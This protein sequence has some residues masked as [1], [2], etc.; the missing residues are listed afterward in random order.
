MQV[1]SR[2]GDGMGGLVC[3]VHISRVRSQADRT[4]SK[5][6]VTERRQSQNQKHT[7]IKE[8]AY[9]LKQ[10]VLKMRGSLTPPPLDALKLPPVTTY[11]STWIWFSDENTHPPC[12]YQ[13]PTRFMI[14]RLSIETEPIS[15]PSYSSPMFPMFPGFHDKLWP[16]G[17]WQR[18]T[19]NI[20]KFPRR[21]GA[22]NSFPVLVHWLCTGLNGK[23]NADATFLSH[24]SQENSETQNHTGPPG[25]SLGILNRREQINCLI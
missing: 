25:Q 3:L 21:K 24:E 4:S 12:I 20:L 5:W 15:N 14:W 7:P 16:L 22:G 13:V 9:F 8:P 1:L 10:E 19:C 17:W 2:V 11:N 18:S 6:P 23:A